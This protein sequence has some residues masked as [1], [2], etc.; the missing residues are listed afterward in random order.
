M[1][2]LVRTPQAFIRSLQISRVTLNVF[3]EGDV[4]SYFYGQVC[5]QVTPGLFMYQII[6][7][8]QLAGSGRG[9]SSLIKLFESMRRRGLL[10]LDFKGQR[11]AALFFVDKDIDDLRRKIRRSRH[12]IYTKYY[13]VENYA[14]KHGKLTVAVSAACLR[15]SPD[16]ERI[17]LKP[18]EWSN[19]AARLWIDWLKLC[20]AGCLLNASGICNYSAPSSVNDDPCA[21]VNR[22]LFNSAF[23]RLEGVHLF[24]GC[25]Y[26]CISG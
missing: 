13:E 5:K 2:R 23:R 17:I 7:S 12:I 14:F 20:L 22:V 15:D 25:Q 11:S 6:R 18:E 19:R 1:N 26:F 24:D 8:D 9:K 16:V 4:D 21:P 10:V 3:V